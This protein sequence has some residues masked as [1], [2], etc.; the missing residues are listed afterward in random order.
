MAVFHSMSYSAIQRLV[1]L[2]QIIAGDLYFA[3][4]QVGSSQGNLYIAATDG[5]LVPMASIILSGN[6]TGEPGA[7]GSAGPIGPTGATGPQGP[8]GS[9]ATK[10]VVSVTAAY[11]TKATD[12][13]L[14]VNFSAPAQIV[15]TTD[16]IVS[17]KTYTVTML[18]GSAE[19]LIVAEGGAPIQDQTDQ[20]SLLAGD[21]VD[22]C[23][24]AA[25]FV[26]Q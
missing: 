12:D 20:V 8:A 15:L 19:G 1:Q 23:W 24:D 6:I 14:F 7:Q 16:G 17:G 3:N 11:T 10:N 9:S 4:D 13:V 25:G 2:G 26:I 5:A 21:S 22:F 18:A